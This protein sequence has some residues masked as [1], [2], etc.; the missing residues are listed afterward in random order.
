MIKKLLIL[1]ILCTSTIFAQNGLRFDGSNDF[2]QTNY[3]GILGSNARTIEAWIKTTTVTSS[4]QKVIVDWGSNGTGGR[5]TFCMLQNNSIRLEVG[6]NGIPGTLAVNNGVWRHVAAVYD[7][8]LSSN[9]VK[10]YIDGNL[11]ASGNLTVAVNTAVGSN[12]RIGQR[13]DGVNLFNGSIDEVRIWNVART[14]SEISANKNIELCGPQPGLVAYYKLNEGVA[15]G[16][17]TSISTVADSSGNGYNGTLTNFALTGT[18]SNFVTGATLT[19]NIINTVT[20]TDNTTLT[21]N[22]TGATYQWLDCNNANASISGATSQTFA[23]SLPG[24]Y[25][26]QIT[27][28]D[29]STTSTCNSIT[30]SSEI[31]SFKNSIQLFPN[32]T[33]GI[34]NIQLNQSFETIEATVYNITGQTILSKEFKNTNS[35]SLDI[36]SSN[37][38][39]FLSIETNSGENAVLKV[40]KN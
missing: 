10:L 23:P 4:N 37:G 11:N 24:S 34:T 36:N 22:Q 30:L 19:Q 3:S 20:V 32:P 39:Y 17:N 9:Q 26:V 2:V 40:I 27:L 31:F 33:I 13:F 35:F 18:S 6:G 16:T 28:N 29:C 38:V 12:L 5:F 21:A 25:A 1:F 14:A 8:S 15:G 7:P